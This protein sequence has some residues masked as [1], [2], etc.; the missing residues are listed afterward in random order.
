MVGVDGQPLTEA[1]FVLS[2]D[3][4]ISIQARRR[5]HLSY[6]PQPAPAMKAEHEY[7]RCGAWAYLAAL[8]MLRA[9]SFGHCEARNGIASFDRLVEQVM[10]QT[11]NRS[12]HRGFWLLNNGSSPRRQRGLTRLQGRCPN[13]IVVP[14]PVHACWLNHI[15]IYFS[16]LPRKRLT[17]NDFKSIKNLEEHLIEFQNYYEQIAKPM[18]GNSSVNIWRPCSTN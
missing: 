6:L 8:D 4:K 3:E 11:P 10:T 12:A 16:I 7:T 9:K 1:D 5:K 15:E 18:N 13:P 2:A 14:A 17:P